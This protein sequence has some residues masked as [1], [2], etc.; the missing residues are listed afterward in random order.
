MKFFHKHSGFK[1]EAERLL[2][3]PYPAGV[4]GLESDGVTKFYART[5]KGNLELPDGHWIVRRLN[6]HGAEINAWV[7][8][9]EEFCA[10]YEQCPE[11]NKRERRLIAQVPSSCVYLT[12]KNGDTIEVNLGMMLFAAPGRE[13]TEI[14]F[15]CGERVLVKEKVDEL[16]NR[17]VLV[18]YYQ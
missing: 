14:R 11:E 2:G 4:Y 9:H 1:V 16:H 7:K 15:F 5:S 13:T 17:P 12:D 3:P 8:S 18:K 6:D 10:D